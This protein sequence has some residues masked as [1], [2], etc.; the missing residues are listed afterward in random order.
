[1]FLSPL[2]PL[3]NILYRYS[4]SSLRPPCLLPWKNTKLTPTASDSTNFL[5]QSYQ[6]P[7]LR[8]SQRLSA[9]TR[10]LTILSVPKRTSPKKTPLSLPVYSVYKNITS[11]MV[12]DAPAKASLSAMSTV[13][14]TSSC[15]RLP[16][17]SSSCMFTFSS[18][19]YCHSCC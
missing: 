18:G 2:P 5:V 1:M 16:M 11:S 19:S 17:L 12:C 10:Y 3:I 13:T 15:F 8:T 14:R 4:S 9:F 7:S 6:L